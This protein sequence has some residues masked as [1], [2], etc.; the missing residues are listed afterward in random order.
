MAYLTKDDL[1]IIRNPDTTIQERVAVVAGRIRRL[2][3]PR[4]DGS[5]C[6]TPFVNASWAPLLAPSFLSP[7]TS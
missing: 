5:R 7:A 4:A 2:A 1:V 6:L 3:R